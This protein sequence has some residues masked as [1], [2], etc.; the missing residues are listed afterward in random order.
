VS[1]S[2]LLAQ[3]WPEPLAPG[4]KQRY[5]IDA[6]DMLA[7]H[8]ADKTEWE[9]GDIIRVGGY[10]AECIVGGRV[11]SVEPRWLPTLGAEIQDGSARWRI[12]APSAA[13][14]KTTANSFTWSAPDGIT[15]SDQVDTTLQSTAMLEVAAN[16]PPGKYTVMVT[17][18]CA[19]TDA[20][21]RPCVLSVE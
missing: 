17:I 8:W 3:E 11:G 12:V 13:S 14:L 5:K 7:Y 16:Q 20:P 10:D 9:L 4:G 18:T 21:R 19:N 15:V 1:C 6:S 2:T